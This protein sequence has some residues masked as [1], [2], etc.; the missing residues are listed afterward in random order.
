LCFGLIFVNSGLFVGD[1]DP[2]SSYDNERNRE[3]QTMEME[4]SFDRNVSVFNGFFLECLEMN[5][6]L[7]LKYIKLVLNKTRY[8]H[9]VL[10]IL[11]LIFTDDLVFIKH[12]TKFSQMV[13][14]ADDM[15]L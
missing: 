1:D 9:L 7:L 3:E 5:G 8:R 4:F 15:G 11:D 13:T 6:R 12:S 14:L 10:E 2:D